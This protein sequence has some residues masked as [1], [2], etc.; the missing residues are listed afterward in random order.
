M[1]DIFK[2]MYIL[3]VEIQELS[4][5]FHKLKKRYDKRHRACVLGLDSGLVQKSC[6]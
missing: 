2:S 1:I 5:F 6:C 3:Y 4:P